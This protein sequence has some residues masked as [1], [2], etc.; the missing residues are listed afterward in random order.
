MQ[1]RLAKIKWGKYYSYYSI[2]HIHV[3]QY[4]LTY[5]LKAENILQIHIRCIKKKQTKT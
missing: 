3:H 2:N 5:G 1:T 4:S